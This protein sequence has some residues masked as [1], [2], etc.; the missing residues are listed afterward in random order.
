MNL[1]RRPDRRLRG[2]PGRP[3]QPGGARPRAVRRRAR[4]GPAGWPRRRRS[5]SRRSSALGPRPTS[6]R[7]WP[8]RPRASRARSA[9]RTPR[10]ASAPSWAS[11]GR[12]SRAG[13][14]AGHRR[15]V[16][17]APGRA[18]PRAPSG[19]WCSP[20]PGCRCPSGHP[21][22]PHAG[23]RAVGGR[24]P[25]GG[26][27]HRRLAA[28]PRP[29]LELLRAAL[30]LADRQAAQPRARGGGRARAARASSA[31]SSPRTSTACTGSPASARLI[32]V[33]GSIEWSICL[34]CR[35]RQPLEHVVELLEAADGA[36]D[37]PACVAPL[38]PDVVLFGEL[39]ARARDGGGAGSWR[40]R[41]T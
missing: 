37:C 10:R 24:R 38:K 32:E 27:A 34:E 23:Q 14:H 11:A 33:H 19:R 41:P 3:R 40:P 9:P 26:G 4:P 2:A 6:T 30:R 31:G 28:R 39:P 25:D 18:A 29:L 35:G 16:G 12:S 1:A 5:R 17:R 22:L 21:R 20:A 13:E 7:A 15:H 8:A 36:P